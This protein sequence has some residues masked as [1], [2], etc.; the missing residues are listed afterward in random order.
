MTILMRYQ[1]AAVKRYIRTEAR[2][3]RFLPSAIARNEI[4]R[5]IVQLAERGF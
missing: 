1:L 3:M 4:R 5:T 2:W